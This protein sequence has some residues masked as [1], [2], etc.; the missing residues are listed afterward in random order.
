MAYDKAYFDKWYR[1]AQHQV[2]SSVELRRQVAFVL[3]TAEALLN[4]PIRTVLDVGAGE[5]QWHAELKKLRPR[6]RYFGVDPSEYAVSRFGKR[7]NVHLG[8]AER[9]GDVSGIPD[10]VDLLVCSSVLNYLGD[11]ALKAALSDLARRTDGMAYLEIYTREDV[12]ADLIEGDIAAMGRH[13]A[14]WWRTQL[15]RAG[16]ISCGLHCYVTDR[17]QGRVTAMERQG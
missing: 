13:D 1:S 14:R 10:G 8:S 2:R 15:R 7:R 9:L 6:I 16:F 17:H 5:G 3:H 12:E 11:D 4:Q